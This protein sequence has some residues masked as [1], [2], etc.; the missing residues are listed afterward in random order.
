[1]ERDESQR[2]A[3]FM[4][5]HPLVSL[6]VLTLNFLQLAPPLHSH[7]QS[8]CLSNSKPSQVE[9]CLRAWLLGQ[10]LHIWYVPTQTFQN[11][12]SQKSELFFIPNTFEVDIHPHLHAS[13]QRLGGGEVP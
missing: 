12:K 9:E 5:P 8:V 7:A 13:I 10:G 6:K 2:L 3:G 1:M 4:A 11:P